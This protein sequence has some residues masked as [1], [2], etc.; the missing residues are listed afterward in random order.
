[1]ISLLIVSTGGNVV[2]AGTIGRGGAA[3]LQSAFGERRSYT[4]ATI[5]IPGIFTTISAVDFRRAASDN[6]LIRDL[7]FRYIEALWAETQQT[8]ACNAIH[9]GCQRLCR[10]L[11]QS[12]DCI[13]SDHLP[14]T[15]EYL[16]DMLGLRR[17]TVTLLAQDLRER[18]VIRYSRG[19]IMLLDR[20]ALEARACECYEATKG[21]NLSLK[22]G[23]TLINE[24]TLLARAG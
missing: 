18:G 7:A 10:W 12:A 16:A 23:G 13:G 22:T 2:E 24:S 17:T 6:G 3:G 9:N 15:Q 20:K 4:R 8:V 11:L 1:M 19:R 21:E 14:L 5:Q